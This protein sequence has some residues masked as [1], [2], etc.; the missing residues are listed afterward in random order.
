MNGLFTELLT[1]LQTLP[2]VALYVALGAAAAIENVFPPLPT[3]SIVALGAFLAARGEGTAEAA[4]ASIF[5]GNLLGASVAY[6]AGR[7]LGAQRVR[8]WIFGPPKAEEAAEERV[9]ALYIRYG[10]LAIFGMRLVPAVRAVVAPLAGA[11]RVPFPAALAVM[12]LASGLWYGLVMWLA[13]RVSANLDTVI[14]TVTRYGRDMTVVVSALA[15]VAV[16]A[17][18][19]HRRRRA[20]VLSEAKDLLV[21]GNSDEAE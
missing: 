21:P 16:L 18:W 17:W 9:R 7:R 3:D 15:V 14:A 1:W 20:V 11:L 10:L 19:Y 12:A 4:F 13:Y 2:P 8:S 5:A 6:W